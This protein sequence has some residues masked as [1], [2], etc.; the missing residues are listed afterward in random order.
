MLRGCLPNA[1]PDGVRLVEGELTTLRPH[2]LAEHPLVIATL[3][4]IRRAI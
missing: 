4:Q 1:G 2:E 3:E